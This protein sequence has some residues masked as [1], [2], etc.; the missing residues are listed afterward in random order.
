[1][2]L[3]VY[4]LT[5]LATVYSLTQL[6]TVYSLTQLA[7]VYSLTQLATV[8]SLTQLATVYSLT[9][10]AKVSLK[11]FITL[12]KDHSCFKFGRFEFPS[13]PGDWGG[14]FTT[15]VPGAVIVGVAAVY[16]YFNGYQV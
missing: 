4:S 16:V 10:L 6:A 7:T 5:Q 13:R 2:Y 3:W 8:Y 12:Y 14:I 15:Q 1:M 11:V 9:Q